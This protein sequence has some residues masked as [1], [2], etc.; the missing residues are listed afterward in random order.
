MSET[1]SG[2]TTY[3][4]IQSESG[5]NARLI[6]R[7]LMPFLS[8]LI[9]VFRIDQITDTDDIRNVLPVFSIPRS[10]EAENQALSDA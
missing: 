7:A 9:N 6:V 2:T 4:P 5:A 10:V 1:S 8:I 3:I